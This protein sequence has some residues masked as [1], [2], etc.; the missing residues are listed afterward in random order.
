MEPT[1]RTASESAT[2]SYHS[3][4]RALADEFPRFISKLRAYTFW[5]D[6]PDMVFSIIPWNTPMISATPSLF[7]WALMYA[8]ETGGHGPGGGTWL[9]NDTAEAFLS[10]NHIP[11]VQRDLPDRDGCICW[12]RV[13]LVSFFTF[14]MLFELEYMITNA[15]VSLWRDKLHE[16]LLRWF[17][18]TDS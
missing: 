15:P 11:I 14:L 10:S 7:A 9:G 17:K 18:M 4:L 16:E 2:K 3:Q 6:R 12:I 13:P 8:R 1:A 5:L